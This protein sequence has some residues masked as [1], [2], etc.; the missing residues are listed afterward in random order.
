[1]IALL[2]RLQRLTRYIPKNTR[3]PAPSNIVQTRIVC[4][5]TTY[6][7]ALHCTHSN[8]VACV[9]SLLSTAS[10]R[11]IEARFARALLVD[12]DNTESWNCHGLTVFTLLWGVPGTS[13]TSQDSQKNVQDRGG[14]RPH[15]PGGKEVSR[16]IG[17]YHR[18][19]LFTTILP[20]MQTWYA[21]RS[22]KTTLLKWR[23][24]FEVAADE[25]TAAGG[26]LFLRG[27]FL[28]A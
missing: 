10:I 19:I 16:S 12:P 5:F 25:Y 22:L 21:F 24:D 20:Y 4:Q 6:R 8:C 1:M 14:E 7:R 26:L 2:R 17:H 9:I 13:R 23:P 27:I 3:L 15:T 18:A 28:T 11:S